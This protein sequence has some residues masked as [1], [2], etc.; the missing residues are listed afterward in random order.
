ML[1]SLEALVGKV[2]LRDESRVRLKKRTDVIQPITLMSTRRCA[3]SCD[4]GDNADP[5]RHEGKK[6]VTLN[7]MTVHGHADPAG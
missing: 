6:S 2:L 1:P 4:K 3:L 7:P 5:M